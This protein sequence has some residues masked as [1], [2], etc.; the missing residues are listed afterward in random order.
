MPVLLRSQLDRS[1]TSSRAT[2]IRTTSQS[3]LRPTSADNQSTSHVNATNGSA[4]ENRRNSCQ[5][6]ASISRR[7]VVSV[8]DY[9]NSKA[10]SM[11]RSKHRRL[12]KNATLFHQIKFCYRQLHLNYLIPLLIIMLYMVIGAALFLWIEAPADLQKKQSEYE[13]YVHERELLLKRLE[14]IYTDRAAT[15]RRQRRL[16]LEEAIDYFHERVDLSFPNTTDWSLTTALYY[17]GTVFT[18]IG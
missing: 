17:S 2:A 5:S 4:T 16:F 3:V 7:T 14:E 15:K 11:H 8:I 12:S 6:N 10:T 18:T 9:G 13:N 1:R